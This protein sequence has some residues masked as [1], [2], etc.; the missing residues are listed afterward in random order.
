MWAASMK[1]SNRFSF[2]TIGWDLLTFIGLAMIV[3]A[4]WLYDERVG[5]IA[6]GLM[7]VTA[8]LIAYYL[9]RKGA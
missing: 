9:S 4:L 1:Q 2:R 3:H 7:L 6:C 8:G 5:E